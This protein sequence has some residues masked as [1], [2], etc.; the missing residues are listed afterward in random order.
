MKLGCEDKSNIHV[1]KSINNKKENQQA[2]LID[3]SNKKNIKIRKNN[4]LILLI[5]SLLNNSSIL[6][7]FKSQSSEVTLKIKETGN[8]K[9]FSD[10]F[11]QLNN[12]CAIKINNIHQN[13]LKNEYNFEYT[14]NGNEVTIIWNTDLIS[15]ASMF[16]DCSQISE[17]DLSKFDSKMKKMF[18]MFVFNF[19]KF[20]KL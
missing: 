19:N 9:I 6:C 16:Q 2:N 1:K 8:I 3:K 14:E 4:L 11:F 20:R 7:K 15:T 18:R 5:I 17:I 13:D 10:S 12:Q